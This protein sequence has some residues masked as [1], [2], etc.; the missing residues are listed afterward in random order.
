MEITLIRVGAGFPVFSAPAGLRLA[1]GAAP[2][3]LR[4][5]MNCRRFG[6]FQ[7]CANSRVE[8]VKKTS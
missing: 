6:E 5:A 4:V 3:D 1:A 8:K 2:F 7:L